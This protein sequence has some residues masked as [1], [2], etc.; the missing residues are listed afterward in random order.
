M[1]SNTPGPTQPQQ[2]AT[3]GVALEALLLAFWAITVIFS[4]MTGEHFLTQTGNETALGFFTLGIAALLGVLAFFIFRGSKWAT[5]PA[6]TL[7][8]LIIGGAVTSGDFLDVGLMV[9]ISA[10][11]VGVALV[12][13]R[14]RMFYAR[15]E[16]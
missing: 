5:G 2:I 1:P 9:L 10:F 13:I 4:G 11:A 8:V 16:D 7:Q 12:L 14:L 15:T 3:A 6:I